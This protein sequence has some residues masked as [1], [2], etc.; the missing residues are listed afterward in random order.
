MCKTLTTTSLIV[1]AV[2]GLGPTFAHAGPCSAD[3]AQFETAIR[4]SAGNPLAGLTARQSV[5]AQLNHQPTVASVKRE[6][7]RLKSQFAAIMAR[8]KRLDARGDRAGCSAA[9]DA[10]KQMYIL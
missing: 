2:L 6:N 4:Q 5:S 9:L 10:A 7:E 8:A 3:I 1:C